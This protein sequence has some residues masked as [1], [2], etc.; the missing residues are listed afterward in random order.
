MNP[1]MPVNFSSLLSSIK[2]LSPSQRASI[3]KELDKY[4]QS[5]NDVL[6]DD[7]RLFLNL[8]FSNDNL[9]GERVTA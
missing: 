7:E 8:L 6:S 5:M 1:S 9:Q 4:E 3:R 2:H